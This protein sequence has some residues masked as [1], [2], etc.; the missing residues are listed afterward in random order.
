MVITGSSRVRF[1]CIAGITCL[2]LVTAD[3]SVAQV[4][5]GT[6]SGIV[7]D[8]ADA[9]VPGASVTLIN[10][11]TQAA[12]GE[13]SDRGGHFVFTATPP[14]NYTIRISA[15]GFTT[16]ERTGNVLVANSKLDIGQVGLTVGQ[17]KE[18]ISVSAQAELAQ[19]GSAEN[20]AVLTLDQLANIQDRSRDVMGLLSLLP[21]VVSGTV[22]NVPN[23]PGYG[24]VAPN[25]MGHPANW[26]V[27]TVDGLVSND[28]GNAEFFSSPDL[29]S[30]DEAQVQITN[31]DA[32]YSGNGGAVVNLITKAGTNKFHGSGY[33]YNRNED[34]NANNFFNNLQGL[35][36]PLYRYNTVGGDLGGPI[37]IKSLRDRLFFF[38]SIE[39]WHVT[40]PNAA[41]QLTMPTAA[42]RTGDFSQTID[43][44][45]ALIPI[46]DPLNGGAAFP[47]NIVPASRINATGQAM[48]NL[49]PLPNQL[50][51]TVTKGNYNDQF[52]TS[53]SQP[54]TKPGFPSRLATFRQR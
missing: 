42:E 16:V 6:I 5:S 47:G 20:S 52:Q 38:Y 18:S 39:N 33:W 50:N 1:T 51:R 10:E 32:E 49:F 45:G 29:D 31:Y 34:Y 28:A 7:V 13:K 48:L 53:L 30:L 14:G 24:N 44:N 40:T 11:G 9:V 15:P 26:T 41:G 43:L 12:R 22:Y 25:I 54:K 8:S 35:P 27:A 23:G 3:P 37:P 36:R 21:G 2:L 4:V 46:K 17:T 19:T